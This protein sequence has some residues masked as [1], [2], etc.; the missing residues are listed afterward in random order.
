MIKEIKLE[1][2]GPLNHLCATNLGQINVIIGGNGSGKTF[3]LKSIYAAVRAQEEF[4]RG[5]DRRDFI[6]VLSDKLYWTYQ[7]DK[8]G[9]LVSKGD[10]NRLKMTMIQNDNCSLVFDFGPDTSKKVSVIHNNLAGREANSIFLPP[11]EVL[12]LSKVILKSAL[13]DR[14][15]GF[16]STYVDLVL[17]LQGPL[18]R[19]RNNDA[20]KQSR[21]KLEN[22]FQGK[23]EYDQSKESWIYKK[24]NSRFSINATAEG[25][26]KIAILDTLLGNR[27]ISPESIIFIDEPESALHPTAISQL[28]EIVYILAE[29]GI[30]FFIATHSYFVVKKLHVLSLK[31]GMRMPVLMSDSAGA[32]SQTLL[33]DGMPNNPI[34]GESVRLFE[35]EMEAVSS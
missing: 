10:Q 1:N 34:I 18:V 28:M 23:L 27:Y 15:F 2:F 30:Q 3:L 17:A 26:K 35:E 8:L 9:D 4:G 6:E 22:I 7:V 20:F 21:I 25:I 33:T 14:A 5:D 16:D 13:Q 11:K 19:G 24:G 32:W 12:S 29:K 31:K